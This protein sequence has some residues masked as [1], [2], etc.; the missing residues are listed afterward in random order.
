[1][2]NII[3]YLLVACTY[4]LA[5]QT[6]SAQAIQSWTG[7]A[8]Y[9]S[10]YSSVAGDVVG[11]RFE[12]T[13]SVS[14]DSL[15]V[16][17]G[18]STGAGVDSDHQ[19][20]IWDSTMTLIASTTVTPT[21]TVLGE[22]RYEAITPVAL[23]TGMVYTI[24][25]LYTPTDNDNY[26]SSAS[27]VVTAS[28][29][30]WINAVYPSA[31]ELGFVFPANDSAT[32]SKGRFGP[33]FTFSPLATCNW[34]CGTGVNAATDGYVVTSPATLGGT[35]GATVTGCAS[36]S[37]GAVLVAYASSLTFP[38]AWGEILVDVT[39]PFGELMGMPFAFTDPAVFSF[40]VPSDP[41]FAGLV[42]YTQAASFGGGMCL[43]CAYECTVGY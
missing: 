15:G 33:N 40:P 21:S 2:K 13:F 31:A 14:V 10:Y 25:S 19:V 32:G 1:M 34:Y 23:S 43:H 35:F 26:I 6:A 7:G 42:F 12:V 18:D 29:V 36:G 9:P 28:G 16:W 17:N 41:I 5:A 4:V 38:H 27:D 22:F 37:T 20:G 3:C 30:T 39:D 24:G 11:Y 8:E